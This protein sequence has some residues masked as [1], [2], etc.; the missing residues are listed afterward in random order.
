[1][2][3]LITKQALISVLLLFGINAFTMGDMYAGEAS[4]YGIYSNMQ[5]LEGDFSG[6]EFIILPSNEG[7]FLI[8][9]HAEGWP[10]KPLILK[11]KL[12]GT[13]ASEHDQIRF[14]HPEMGPFEGKITEGSLYGE[15]TEMK[16]TIKLHKGKSIWQ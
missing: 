14:N 1:M 10:M 3:T 15:F 13:K 7:D 2:K 8:F 5:A 12:G 16:H 9:Q 11:V 4:K 6:F